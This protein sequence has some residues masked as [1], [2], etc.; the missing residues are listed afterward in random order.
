MTNIT[1]SGASPA[2]FD[3]TYTHYEEGNLCCKCCISVYVEFLTNLSRVHKTGFWTKQGKCKCLLTTLKDI[4]EVAFFHKLRKRE[5]SLRHFKQF[6]LEE[7]FPKIYKSWPLPVAQSLVQVF[8]NSDLCI[9]WQLQAMN[10][11]YW[12][13]FKLFIKITIM[14]VFQVTLLI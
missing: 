5:P 14:W 9:R 4:I 8:E 12:T 7:C 13:N 10:G 1:R 2:G 3:L 11:C 6:F